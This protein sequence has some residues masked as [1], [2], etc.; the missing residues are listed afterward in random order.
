MSYVN[1]VRDIEFRR[2]SAAPRDGTFVFLY[3]ANQPGRYIATWDAGHNVW[4]GETFTL[5]AT[6]PIAWS[7][8]SDPE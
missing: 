3:L 6:L 4:R 5:P 8:M 7:I 1:L 2:M